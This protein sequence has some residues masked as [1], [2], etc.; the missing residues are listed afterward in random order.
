MGRSGSG[1]YYKDFQRYGG[2]GNYDYRRYLTGPRETDEQRAARKARERREYEERHERVDV[3]H[4]SSSRG[5][6]SHK[7]KTHDGRGKSHIVED[8]SKR[9]KPSEKHAS[10]ISEK[11]DAPISIDIP[12]KSPAL[13]GSAIQTLLNR[14]SY[15]VERGP[16]TLQSRFPNWCLKGVRFD[17]DLVPIDKE[18]MYQNLDAVRLDIERM[19]GWQ[20]LV[21]ELQR[22]NRANIE[23]MLTME[24]DKSEWQKILDQHNIEMKNI[25]EYNEKL[26][27]EVKQLKDDL[28]TSSNT[29]TQREEVLQK[30]VRDAH[31]GQRDAEAK[32]ERLEEVA[33]NY[34]T[35]VARLRSKMSAQDM[36]I[37]ALKSQL[38]KTEKNEM[39][40][41]LVKSQLK[42]LFKPW[43]PTSVQLYSTFTCT[44]S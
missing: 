9:A 23:A 31:A 37:E 22:V 1:S 16:P 7:R 26:E 30:Q 21:D 27:A 2:R 41:W 24:N 3:R 15:R 8:P 39:R 38:A 11:F 25:T 32:V 34:R 33:E 14:P 44:A 13:E 19:S 29:Y 40:P 28:T 42:N 10:A 4:E 43:K 36:E 18:A 12:S 6:D 17:L 35:D 20:K 5:D